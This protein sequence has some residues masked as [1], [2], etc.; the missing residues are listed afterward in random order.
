MKKHFYPAVFHQEEDGY[1]VRFPDLDGCYTEGDTIDEA[2][3]M[4]ADAIGLF[5]E[6]KEN[7]FIYPQAS[8]PQDVKTDKGEFVV[9]VEF[10]ELAYLKQHDSRAVKKTLTIPS[11]MNHMAEEKNIN[12]SNLLQNA[13]SEQLGL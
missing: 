6:T 1:S 7:E 4:C 11:W 9:L 5:V 2:Y 10:D 8:S 12:F 3:A 13:L